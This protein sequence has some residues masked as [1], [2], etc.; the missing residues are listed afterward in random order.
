MN[1]DL[2]IDHSSIHYYDA[3]YPSPTGPFAE[4]FDA[5]TAAQGIADDVQRYQQLA[6]EVRGDVLELCCG[7]GRVAIPLARAGLR[8]TAVD[9]S[10]GM[11]QRLA[12]N[13]AREPGSVA[14]RVTAIEQDVT[15]LSL[16]RRDYA[17]AIVAFNSLLCITE[18]EAQLAALR[19]ISAH[20]AVGGK[21]VLDVINPLVLSVAGDPKPKAFFTRR[22]PHTG[23]PYTRFAMTG[24]FDAA[25]RQEL[26]GW[27]DELDAEGLVRRRPYSMRWRPIFRYEL[28]LMLRAAGLRVTALE[29]DHQGAPFSATSSHLFVQAVKES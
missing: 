12:A 1:A 29:G 24:P 26:Y 13:L 20:L 25:Q 6:A 22:N 10:R 28:E 18:F 8:V 9:V 3:D 7:T 27:Y 17:L 21:L 16:P 14:E 19:S 11:L 5:T 4:N 15:R 2:P 23:N